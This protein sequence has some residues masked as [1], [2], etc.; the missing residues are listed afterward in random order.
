M[1]DILLADV[2]L[3]EQVSGERERKFERKSVS[4]SYLRLI[5]FR[6]FDKLILVLT[7]N[8]SYKAIRY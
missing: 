1:C 3:T 2:L 7:G 6:D 8:E 5:P 4:E